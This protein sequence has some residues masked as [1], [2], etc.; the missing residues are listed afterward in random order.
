MQLHEAM[1]RDCGSS[2]F[3]CFKY[4][5]QSTQRRC[6]HLAA[7]RAVRSCTEHTQPLCASSP[8]LQGEQQ[9]VATLSCLGR[10]NL[11]CIK[12]QGSK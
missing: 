5:P 7:D 9:W 10:G 1:P 4:Q 8:N 11:P 6:A 12:K 2:L 3:L